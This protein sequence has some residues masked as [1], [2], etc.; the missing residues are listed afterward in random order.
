MT[1]DESGYKLITEFEGLRLKPYL[2]SVGVPTIGYGSTYYE[3]GTK[4]KMTDKPITKKRAFQLFQKVADDFAFKVNKKLFRRVNQNQFNALVSLA[5]NIG[6][7]NFTEST[8]LDKVNKN[9]LDRD[10]YNQ[11]LRWNKGGGRVIYGLTVRRKREAE[12]YNT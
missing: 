8:L 1:L 11:F 2:D 5:Y 10:I 3:D 9:P 12:L 7:G 6:M 4:V